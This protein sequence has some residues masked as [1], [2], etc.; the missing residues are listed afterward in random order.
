MSI[1]SASGTTIIYQ[2]FR[3]NG[4]PASYEPTMPCEIGL[5]HPGWVLKKPEFNHQGAHIALVVGA[6]ALAAIALGIGGSLV[7]AG[8]LPQGLLQKKVWVSFISYGIALLAG[9]ISTIAYFKEDHTIKLK[10]FEEKYTEE[11]KKYNEKINDFNERQKRIENVKKLDQDLIKTQE[12]S[13]STLL[14]TCESSEKTIRD[15]HM[16]LRAC[17]RQE[18][19][20]DDLKRLHALRVTGM[21]LPTSRYHI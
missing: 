5:F 21:R 14:E 6:I 4:I 1:V 13:I 9:S 3:K 19:D 7:K 2:N 18:K 20:L 16:Q 8:A 11:Y 17:R 15:L 10:K 12:E